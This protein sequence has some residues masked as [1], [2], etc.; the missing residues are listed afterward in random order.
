MNI[1]DSYN[2]KVLEPIGGSIDKIYRILE[3][4]TIA[5]ASIYDLVLKNLTILGQKM[6]EGY[7]KVAK[8]FEIVARFITIPGS[9]IYYWFIKK[10]SID[11]KS[12]RLNSSH[13]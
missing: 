12:T 13:V 5:A 9:F 8:Q 7:T 10:W 3:K 1:T 4:S 6:L 2:K 11:R